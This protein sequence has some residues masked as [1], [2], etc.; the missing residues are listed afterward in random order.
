MI[1]CIYYILIICTI[2]LICNIFLFTYIVCVSVCI[3]YTCNSVKSSRLLG[4]H[5][6]NQIYANNFKIESNLRICL[7]VSDILHFNISLSFCCSVGSLP[8][9]K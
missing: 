6:E 7:I 4:S 3:L 8:T 1:V 5:T 2:C 9:Q